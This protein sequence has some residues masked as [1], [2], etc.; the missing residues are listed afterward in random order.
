MIKVDCPA[1]SDQVARLLRRRN[2][3]KTAWTSRNARRVRGD[4]DINAA[5]EQAF[6]GKCGY[7]EC[8]EAETIDH[9]W[10][11][12]PHTDKIWDWDNYVW[13]CDAC[14]RRKSNRSPMSDQGYQM[15]NPREDEPLHYLRVDTDTGKIFAA[16]VGGAVEWRGAYTVSILELDQ[17]PDLDRQRQLVY[18]RV[19]DLLV[20]IIDPESSHP[21]IDRAWSRLQ[22]ELDLR[23]PYLAIIQQLFTRP[24]SD[25]EPFIQR[26][27]EVIPDAWALLEHFRR[28]VPL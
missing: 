8:I 1:P 28:P 25:V 20:Q 10:P 13:S 15:V 5:L 11:Q 3:Q 7:C 26:L 24:S 2:Q 14:Q 4:A 16:P 12:S 6:H 23:Q 9:F 21:T 17:R 18:A 19:Y 22:Q 27:Y